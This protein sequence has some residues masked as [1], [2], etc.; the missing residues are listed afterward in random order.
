[1]N[2]NL[3]D[4]FMIMTLYKKYFFIFMVLMAIL[5]VGCSDDKESKTPEIKKEDLNMP[6]E[7]PSQQGEEKRTLDTAERPLLIGVVGPETNEEANYGLSVV[8]GVLAAAK[9]FNAQGGIEG[10]EIKV[11]HF[12][13]KGSLKLTNDITMDLITKGAIAILSAPTGSS[14][15]A[16]VHLVNDYK[17]IFISVGSRRHIERSGP[18]IFRASVSDEQATDDLIKFTSTALGYKNYALVTSSNYDFSLDLSFLFKKAI[19]KHNGAIKVETDSYDSYT[20]GLNMEVVVDA[21]KNSPDALQGVVFTGGVDEGIL[22]AGELKKAGLTLP[23]IGGEDLF[24][25]EYLK[26]GDAVNGTLLY[27]TFSSDN[28]TPE[29]DEFIKGYGKD[30]PDRF[31]ALAYDAFMMVADKVSKVLPGK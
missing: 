16:P 7:K 31:A 25:A 13:D 21:I 5:L 2:L 20:G 14:T 17:T 9:Q 23:L 27:S 4:T 18:Y 29:M 1:L 28:G 10:K 26:G 11:E 19:Y 12:D 15:F 3:V 22:L 6:V 8:G 24:S 30:D